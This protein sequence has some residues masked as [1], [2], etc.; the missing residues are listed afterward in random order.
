MVNNDISIRR[1][2]LK[3]YN[4]E[5]KPNYLELLKTPD[6]IVALEEIIGLPTLG[7]IIMAE[8]ARFQLAFNVARPMNA[9]QIALCA[10]SI[11][12]SAAEDYLSLEDLLVF[13]TNARRGDYGKI[14][15]RLDEQI[16]FQLLEQ[17]REERHRFYTNYQDEQHVKNKASGKSS[18]EAGEITLREFFNKTKQ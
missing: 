5:S 7:K 4:P 6:R 13:F 18:A 2:F 9:Q 1:D 17:Y 11:I 16:I 3:I 12:T 10:E 8:I 15:E 14:Y